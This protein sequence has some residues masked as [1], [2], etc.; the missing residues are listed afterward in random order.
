MTHD[1]FIRIST[2]IRDELNKVNADVMDYQ[3]VGKVVATLAMLQLMNMGADDD[4]IRN[5]I[6]LFADS[7]KKDLKATWSKIKR[8]CIV[9]AN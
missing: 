3:K 5:A 4:D 2:L 7:I 9:I 6:D 1:E 8:N